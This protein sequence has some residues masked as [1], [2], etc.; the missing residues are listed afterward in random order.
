MAEPHKL[1]VVGDFYVAANCCTLCGVPLTVAPSLFAADVDSCY[2]KKQPTTADELGGML[3]VMLT[4]DTRCV[5]YRGNDPAIWWVLRGSGE[6]PA[7]E[8]K[9]G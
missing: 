4:Q 5:H 3:K 8:G 2:V 1:N 6:A 9:S 7:C